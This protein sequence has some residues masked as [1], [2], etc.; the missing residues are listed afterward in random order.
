[1]DT[2]KIERITKG[3][4]NHRRVQILNL[5]EGKPNLSG[6]DI[7]DELG[8]DFRTVAEHLRRL[9]VAGLIVKRNRGRRVENALS[10]TGKK[11]LKFVRTLE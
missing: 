2:R 10:E 3:F 5:L 6:F 9:S 8:V 11:A 4:A 7:S 1:M